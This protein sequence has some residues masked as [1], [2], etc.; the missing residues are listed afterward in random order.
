MSHWFGNTFRKLH[1]LYVS[2]Q[3]AARQGQ[4]FDAVDYAD[5]LERAGV[6]C[7]ELYCKDHHG[8]VYFPCSLGLP[9]PRDILGELLPELKRRGIRLIAYVSVCFDNY[10]LGV[11]PDWRM[12]NNLGDPYKLRPFYMASICSPYTEFVLRQIAEL[13][14]NYAVDGFWLDIIPLARD[15]PQDIWMIAP[16]PMPDYSLHAQKAWEAA[17][18]EQLPLQPTADE[19]DRIFEFMTAQVEAFMNRAYATIRSH[20][21]E[22]VIT[23]NAAG[24]P[25]DPLD[26]AD[27]I[28]IEGHAPNYSRQSFIARWAKTRGKPF[29]LLTAGA[30]PRTA[31]GGGWNGFDQKPLPFLQLENAIA[32]AHGGSMVF[33]TAPY[34]N[35]AT[36]PAQFD[37]FGEVF[38]P[39]KALEPWLPQPEGISDIGLVFAPKPR[40]ASRLWGEMQDG[41]EAWHDALLDTRLQYDIIQ[42]DA[43]LSRYQLLILPD[44]AAL[45]DDEIEKLRAYTR[46]GGKLLA[47]GSSSLYDAD[48][49]RRADFGLADVFGLSYRRAAGS[50]FVYLRLNDAELGAA[51]T[52]MPILID[53]TPLVVACAGAAVIGEFALPEAGRSEATTVLWGDAAPDETS[54]LPGITRH[55][56]GAG[57]CVYAAAPLRAN[58]MPDAWVKRLM[59]LLAASLVETPVLE[60]DAPAGVE[61]ALNRQAGRAVLHLLNRYAG[62]VDYLAWADNPARVNDINIALN[63]SRLGVDNVTRVFHAPDTD[64]DFTIDA[65][66]LRL[67]LPRLELHA[68][69][70]VE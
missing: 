50:E 68:V 4:D 51:A 43:D 34:P 11:H 60:T 3:W 16:H 33:G 9:H 46:G 67:R 40:S 8:T 27:L 58:G 7:L 63:L 48:G 17:T 10:A 19:A 31:L 37:G 18:G 35:G 12:V 14:A 62:T 65:G 36:D 26:S 42:L 44:Q 15:V 56:F 64:L 61:M 24:A 54:R 25:G 23:Y 22:A 41:A 13:A 47:A 57:E 20:L 52:T 32:L 28:S 21:P 1:K 59:G 38:Q 55:R 6:D 29:E 30:L 70:V 2:P 49:K 53:Q 39:V 45:S 5:S 66:R 69:I